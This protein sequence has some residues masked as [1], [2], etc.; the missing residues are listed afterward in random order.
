MPE[1]EPT[2]V[3][4]AFLDAL[5]RLDVDAAVALLDPDVTYQNVPLPAARGVRAVSRQLGLLQRLSGFEAIDHNVAADGGTVL[6]ERTDVIVVGPVRIAFWVVGTFEVR[7]GRILSWRDRFDFF[8]VTRGLV[9]GV[10]R[11]VV[12]R[13]G[14]AARR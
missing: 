6:T 13:G 8:D 4:R 14:S 7:N 10:L 11:A 12:G 3:V 5:E 9:A 2:K 1:T